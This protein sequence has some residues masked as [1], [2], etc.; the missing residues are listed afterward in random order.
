MSFFQI[1]LTFKSL[2]ETSIFAIDNLIIKMKNNRCL[3]SEAALDPITRK[4]SDNIDDALE[5]WK[6]I[7][8][9]A[10]SIAGVALVITI[11]VSILVVN[12][13]KK[14]KYN[15]S[16]ENNLYPAEQTIIPRVDSQKYYY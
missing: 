9:V 15:K 12:G 13:N 11:V 16:Y 8:V 14:V 7:S 10:I 1:R 6:I 4:E 2:A 3:V 5:E